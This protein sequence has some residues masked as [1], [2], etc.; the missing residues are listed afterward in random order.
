MK[1]KIILNSIAVFFIVGFFLHII[2]L[3]YCTGNIPERGTVCVGILVYAT[4]FYTTWNPFTFGLSVHPSEDTLLCEKI[5]SDSKYE[6]VVICKMVIYQYKIIIVLTALISKVLIDALQ[7]TDIFLFGLD[8]LVVL[9][10]YSAVC[11]TIG[12]RIASHLFE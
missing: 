9:T 4:L 8:V 3:W 11:S 7:V 5:I 2:W 10:L 1:I 12:R 6:V